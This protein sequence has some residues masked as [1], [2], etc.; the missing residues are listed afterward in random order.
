VKNLKSIDL[1]KIS[2][3]IFVG[4]LRNETLDL[5]FNQMSKA[6]PPSGFG[7]FGKKIVDGDREYIGFLLGNKRNRDQLRDQWHHHCLNI[8]KEQTLEIFW[9]EE[10]NYKKMSS[11]ERED[12][13]DRIVE[14]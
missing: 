12:F 1:S 8:V 11:D 4:K 10:G 9:Y 6:T 7:E 3:C 5:V 14:Y 2:Y 13:Y